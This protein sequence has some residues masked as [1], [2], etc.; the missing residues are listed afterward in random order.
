MGAGEDLGGGPVELID[1]GVVGGKACIQ[2]GPRSEKLKMMNE[3]GYD[4]SLR[5]FFA[6]A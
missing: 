3:S 1:G 4:I 5:R 6:R 2:G